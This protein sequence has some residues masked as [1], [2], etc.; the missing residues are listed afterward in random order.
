MKA[1]AGVTL[2]HLGAMEWRDD[3]RLHYGPTGQPEFAWVYAANA[4]LE[5]TYRKASAGRTLDRSIVIKPMSAL[6]F[7]EGQPLFQEGIPTLSLIAL[8]DYLCAATADVRDRMSRP[9][10]LEQVETFRA[11]IEAIDRAPT[12]ELTKHEAEPGRLLQW[13]L[14]LVGAGR[15]ETK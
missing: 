4:A 7:G 2:E 15:I 14:R 8:P 6:Y 13:L 10:L 5:R 9:L 12:A 3:A 11:A 1:V